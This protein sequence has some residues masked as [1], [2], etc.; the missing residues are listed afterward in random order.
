MD[1]AHDFLS[2]LMEKFLHMLIKILENIDYVFEPILFYP[3][4]KNDVGGF[5]Q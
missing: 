4:Y 3:I 2:F 1:G 5:F